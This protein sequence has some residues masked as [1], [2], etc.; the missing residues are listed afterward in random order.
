M[1]PKNKF[2]DQT[3]KRKNSRN[4]DHYRTLVTLEF[5]YTQIQTKNFKFNHEQMKAAPSS[6]IFERDSGNEKISK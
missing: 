5:K 4:V 3:G 1:V 6:Q 2:L